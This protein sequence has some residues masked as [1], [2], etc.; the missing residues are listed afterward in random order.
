MVMAVGPSVLTYMQFHSSIDI[1]RL[2]ETVQDLWVGHK[3]TCANSINKPFS[4]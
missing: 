3:T 4:L 1:A 2:L